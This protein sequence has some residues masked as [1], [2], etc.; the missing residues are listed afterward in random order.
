[1]KQYNYKVLYA[2]DD[3]VIRANYVSLLEC[4]FS[5]VYEASNGSEALKR[6]NEYKPDIIILDVNM[7]VLNGLE[8]VKIIRENDLKIYIIMLTAMDS[9]EY[10]LEALNLEINRYLIKPVETKELEAII[11]ET[12]KKLESKNNI[13]KLPGDYIWDR[14]NRILSKDKNIVKLTKKEHLLLA[15]LCSKE[16]QVFATDSILNYVWEDDVDNIYNTLPLRTL[17]SR[18]KNKLDVQVFESIYNVG[19]KIKM[20]SD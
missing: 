9:K 17:V 15:L 19:Y 11:F 5:N 16:T 6:Y 4:Y 18:I 1:M 2:E 10:L 20:V 13:L 12:V 3:D 8:V 14:D 7:P